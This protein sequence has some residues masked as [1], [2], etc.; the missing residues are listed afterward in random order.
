MLIELTVVLVLTLINGLLA[1]SELAIVSSRPARLK[2][3]SDQ[4]SKGARVAMSLAEDP[5]RFLSTVQIGITLVGILSGA[6][7]GA[8]LGIRLATW[9]GEMGIPGAAADALGVGSIVIAITYLSV[10]LGELVPKQIALR[11]PELVA[12]RVAP[13]IRVLLAIFA[14]LVWVLNNSGRAVLGLLG[15][16]G[17]AP[18]RITEE[19]VR[20]LISEAENAGIFA[21][22]E[23]EMITAVMRLADRSA[24]ALMTPRRDVELIDLAQEPAEIIQQIRS[25]PRTRLPVRDGGPDSIVGVV[26]VREILELLL[27]GKSV[28]IRQCVRQAPTLLDLTSA[29]EVLK[30]LQGSEM[31]LALVVD[32]YGHFEGIVTTGNILAAVM[33][34]LSEDAEAEPGL[35]KRG[36]GSLLVSGSLGIDELKDRTGIPVEITPRYQTVAGFVLD[37]F[38]RIPSPGES[39]DFAGWR[40]EVI[41]LDGRRIDKVLISRIQT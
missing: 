27:D 30:A 6:F 34:A 15:Q 31:H 37:C 11:E 8:T 12:L 40:I 16:A 38:G 41:D 25:S 4:G 20:T 2:V 36:D 19:E 24:R 21:H 3:L 18:K 13:G 29:M 10:I 22:G 17:D 23:H 26:V 39:I 33:G 1:M 35:I 14:P 5:G 32:E 7:S 28:D 9:L